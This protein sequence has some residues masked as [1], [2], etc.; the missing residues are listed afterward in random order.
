M[1]SNAT[2]WSCQLFIRKRFNQQGVRVDGASNLP[3]GGVI[4]DKKQVELWIRRAQ[5]AVLSP[6]REHSDFVAM[7]EIELKAT[8]KTDEKTLQFSKNVVVVKVKDPDATDLHFVDLP[9]LSS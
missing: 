6:H 9:G 3:F 1:S 5:A 4:T 8:M 2:S 7:T